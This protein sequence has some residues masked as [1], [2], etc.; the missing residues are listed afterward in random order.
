MKG[1]RARSKSFPSRLQMENMQLF[2]GM[3]RFFSEYL[4]KVQ[5]FLSE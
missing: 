4:E 2:S 3:Q 1:G 5:L